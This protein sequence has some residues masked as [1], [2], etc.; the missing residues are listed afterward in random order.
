MRKVNNITKIYTVLVIIVGIASLTFLI[1]GV[2]TRKW[3]GIS[4]SL[5]PLQT[6]ISRVLSNST[7]ITSLIIATGANQTQ[8]AQIVSATA[9]QVNHELT[10]ATPSDVTY[11]LYGKNPN[12]PQTS[13]NFKLPQGL[14]FAGIALIFLG[15]LLTLIVIILGLPPFVRNLPLFF[16]G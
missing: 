8:V 12:T 1:V 9:E 10:Y 3:I 5:S 7:F 6:Q 13:I 2:A 15:L 11:H 16:L 4:T 14:I